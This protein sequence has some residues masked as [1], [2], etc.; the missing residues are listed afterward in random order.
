MFK[1]LFVHHAVKNGLTVLNVI[2]RCKIIN[3]KKQLKWFL[4]A[5]NVKKYLERTSLC[6][7][8]QINI[9]HIVIISMFSMLLPNKIDD[10]Y[11]I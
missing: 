7:K 4:H 9:V 11:T 10:I 8:N 5:K 2:T 3:L 1:L 6:L